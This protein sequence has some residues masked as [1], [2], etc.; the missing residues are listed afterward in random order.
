M[1]WNHWPCVFPQHGPGRKH[2][3]RI[4]LAAWQAA[5]IESERE[6]FVRVSSTA[7]GCRIIANDRG[8]PSI[9]YHF[10]NLSEDIKHLY[11]ESLDAMGAQWTRPCNQQIAVYRKASVALLD[12]FIG[13]KM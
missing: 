9:R 11:C 4:R 1:C 7:N 6:A 13:P 8:N 2:L 12:R 5:V 3:R 10:S